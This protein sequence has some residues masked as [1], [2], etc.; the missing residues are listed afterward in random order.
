MKLHVNNMLYKQHLLSFCEWLKLLG[1]SESSVYGLP[2]MLQ[3]FFIWLEKKELNQL[4]QVTLEHTNGFIEYNKTRANKRKSGGLSACHINGYIGVLKKFNEYIKQLYQFELPLNAIRL[5]EVAEPRL[6]L[7]T[8]EIKALY[9]TTN[10]TPYGIRDRAM[11]AIYYGCGLRKSE[12]I[13][14]DVSDILI[15]RKMLHVRKSKNNYERYVPITTANLKHIEQYIYSARPLFIAEKSNEQG[16]LISERGTRMSKARAYQLIKT[17][18]SKAG[19]KKEIGLHSL[20]HSIATHLLQS[21]MELENIA[22]F[23]GHRCLDSTQL[24]THI[25]NESPSQPPLKG[26]SS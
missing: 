25:V 20:R 10:E 13:Q 2:K 19:I 3:E 24:Y 5:E 16:L 17:L 22:L 21:G 12:G 11:L 26:R 23:L 1:Y 9:K 15:E 8:E 4:N 7:T 18:S 14:L 6:I